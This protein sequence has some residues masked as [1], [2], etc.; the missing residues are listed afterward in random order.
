MTKL[1][2]LEEKFQS[3]VENAVMVDFSI[4]LVTRLPEVASIRMDHTIKLLRITT[5]FLKLWQ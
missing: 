4:Q 1:M 2:M 3:H 5:S